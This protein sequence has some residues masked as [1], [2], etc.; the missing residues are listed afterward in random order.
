MIR[1]SRIAAA[2]CL[3]LAAGA[4]A[5]SPETDLLFSTPHLQAQPDGATL[6]YLRERRLA[7]D[8]G[9][10]AEGQEPP[11][12][13]SER[14]AMTIGAEADGQRPVEVVVDPDGARRGYDTFRG[15]PGN[16]MLM[17]FLEGV[18]GSVARATGGSPFY[19]RNRIREALADRIARADDGDAALL[20]IRPFA[21]DPN[22]ARLGPF[23]GLAMTFRVDRGAPGMLA[24]MTADAGAAYHEE[25]SLV[26]S[27]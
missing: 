3:L 16:P 20:T 7:L 17:V 25:I 5:A 10:P 9:A 18:A 4:V 8:A 27:P 23:A 12:D 22:R 2:L 11:A 14:I 24:R 13:V 26:P 6:V 1:T 15:V 19:I 21:A